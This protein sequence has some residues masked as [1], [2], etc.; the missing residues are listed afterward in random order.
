MTTISALVIVSLQAIFR[1]TEKTGDNPPIEFIWMTVQHVFFSVIILVGVT[2]W[3][4]G[5]YPHVAIRSL[6]CASCIILVLL[7]YIAI[8]SLDRNFRFQS[9]IPY[10]VG[11]L[12]GLFTVLA[13]ALTLARALGYELAG[14]PVVKATEQTP[15]QAN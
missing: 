12:I 9:G 7:L 8:L 5:A 11:Y 13:I 6:V 4:L 3:I 1:F 15:S 2:Y 14:P 10:V